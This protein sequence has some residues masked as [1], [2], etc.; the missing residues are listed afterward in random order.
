MSLFL[1]EEGRWNWQ[2]AEWPNFGFDYGTLEKLESDFLLQAGTLVGTLKHTGDEDRQSLIVSLISDEAVQT[3]EIEGEILNRDSV[4][5][6]IRRQ[7]GLPTDFRKVSPAEQGIAE[8]LSDL[9]QHSQE[10]LTEKTLFRWNA[11][12]TYGRRDLRDI[13]RYRTGNDPMQVVFGALH[14]PKVHFEAPPAEAVPREMNNFLK[15][16]RGTGPSAD[17]PLP[18]LTRAGIA[19]LYF[20]S[21]HP[22]EDGNGRIGRAISEKS[23]A[24]SLGHPTLISLSQA[25]NSRRKIYYELLERNNQGLEITSWLVYF[26]ETALSAQ[27]ATQKAVDRIIGKAKFSEQYRGQFNE[28]QEKAIVR[29]F[30]EVDDFKGGMSA[31]KYIR[32]TGTSRATATRDLQELIQ[33]GAMSKT[34]TLK[35]T[36]YHLNI[37]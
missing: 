20:V 27:L 21:I 35:S 17:R 31:D 18:L 23:I 12:L 13:G 33:I 14:D 26:A 8:M 16:F 3:S 15:W 36:R 4:Q 29:M 30:R 24:E 34:G 10:P 6:S 1:M 11:M 5:S 9:Y 28:R 7:L 25:I 32:I 37:G 2:K 19:H 22:F